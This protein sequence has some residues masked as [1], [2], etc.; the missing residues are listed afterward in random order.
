M[1]STPGRQGRTIRRSRTASHT[2][3]R[4]V[5]A[6]EELAR[7]EW[8]SEARFG[9]FIHWGVYSVPA[10][11]WKGEEVGGLAEWL[12]YHGRVPVAEYEALAPQFDP[13]K[14]DAEQ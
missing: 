2:G 8:W 11:R 1:T 10:G 9:M 6:P 5:S 13:V 7:L 4:A 14:F 12:M 3:G